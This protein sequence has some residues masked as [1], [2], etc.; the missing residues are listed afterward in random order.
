M[1]LTNNDNELLMDASQDDLSG[2]DQQSMTSGLVGMPHTPLTPQGGGMAALNNRF[3][4]ETIDE[5]DTWRRQRPRS[6]PATNKQRE[7]NR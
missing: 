6:T 1:N 2:L 4:V 3:T 5:N 7:T